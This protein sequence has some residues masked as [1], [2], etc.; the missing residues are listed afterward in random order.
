M[1]IHRSAIIDSQASVHPSVTIGPQVVIEGPVQVGPGCYIAASAVLLGSTVIGAGCQIHSHAVI[2]D[3]PQDRAYEG[4][5]SFC[6][7]GNEC[8]IRE[9]V[10]VHRGTAPGSSTII[11][12]RC[13]LMT[14]A[15]VGHNCVLGDDA[16]LISGALLGGYVEVGA[17]AVISGNAAVH[18]FVRVGELAMVSGLAKVVQDVPPF[19]MTNRDGAVVG[20]NRVGLMRAG[21]SSAERNEIK[22]AFRIIF[23]SGCSRDD[24]LKALS[25]SVVTDAGRR[26]VEFMAKDSARG[27]AKTLDRRRVAA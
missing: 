13:F 27:V 25:E 22:S 26:I 19:F 24:A 15:H 5:E 17:R 10:T 6:R 16:T 4:G 11:G 20:I 21:L 8:I 1:S 14:N 12:H 23:R 9:G 7:I 2:G 3:L 18:Q